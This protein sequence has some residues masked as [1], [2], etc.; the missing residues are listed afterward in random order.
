MMVAGSGKTVTLNG[1]TVG[2]STT[3]QGSSH[4]SPKLRRPMQTGFHACFV[5][6]SFKRERK[7]AQRWVGAWVGIWEELG[8]T[9]Y[10]KNTLNEIV[11]E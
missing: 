6:S 4:P 2:L 10:P 9:E 5:F 7:K 1:V 3:L 8:D 11:K